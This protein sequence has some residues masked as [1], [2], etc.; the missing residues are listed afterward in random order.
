MK[1]V[2]QKLFKTVCDSTDLNNFK[3]I[4]F[5]DNNN[6]SREHRLYKLRNLL[7]KLKK[8]F[9]VHGGLKECL[10]IDENMVPSYSKHYAKQYIRSK[11]NRFGYKNWE[12][13]SSSGY[14][15]S[16]E[17]YTGQ[18]SSKSKQ[19]GIGR[20]TV[21]S[22]INQTNIQPNIEHKIYFDN[23]FSGLHYLHLSEKKKLLREQLETTG[24]QNALCH[25]KKYWNG[26]YTTSMEK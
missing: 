3:F 26:V 9:K 10:S 14:L 11:P 6:I 25:K 20:N 13:C 24:L 15:Y 22:L 5:H 12:M 2:Y 19:F 1:T 8:S 21:L 23:Y 4:H 16:F 7:N 18:D 17:I